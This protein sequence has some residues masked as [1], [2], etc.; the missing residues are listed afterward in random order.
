MS[1]SLRGLRV[2]D[3]LGVF[4]REQD[5]SLMVADEF[6]GTRDVGQIL[7]D[8]VDQRVQ[9]MAHHLPVEPHDL[10]RWGGGSCLFE[11]AG[12]CH[13]GHHETPQQLFTVQAS[14][15]LRRD[16][17]GWSIEQ[18]DN[19]LE[20]RLEFL[21]GHRSQILVLR[22]PDVGGLGKR[23]STVQGDA[24]EGMTIEQLSAKMQETRDLLVTINRL[25]DEI[26][27]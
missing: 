2:V 15:V 19:M 23:V 18:D 11:R 8:F 17:S 5:G 21:V 9:F 24:L 22:P 3:V 16:A 12:H 13:F 1:V 7:V 6:E 27:A 26:D 14:G 20:L 10:S 25:K 4:Y